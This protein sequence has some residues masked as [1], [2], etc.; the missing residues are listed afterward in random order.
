M[1]ERKERKVKD[2]WKGRRRDEVGGKERRGFVGIEFV[3]RREDDEIAEAEWHAI[4]FFNS[5][6]V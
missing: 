1:E 3:M 2:L 5:V 6:L 4:F